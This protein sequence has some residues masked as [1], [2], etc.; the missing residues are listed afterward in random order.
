[1]HRRCLSKKAIV[2]ATAC[3]IAGIGCAGDMPHA[4]FPEPWVRFV[5][6]SQMAGAYDSNTLRFRG[7]TAEIWLRFRTDAPTPMP[8]DSTRIYHVVQVAALIHCPSRRIRDVRSYLANANADSLGGH[9]P[10]APQW[11]SF[12][13]HGLGSKILAPLCDALADKLPSRGA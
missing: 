6:S 11:I 1:M 8:N 3:L 10:D 2:A 9:T 7:D 4:Q 13:E 5:V 12:T